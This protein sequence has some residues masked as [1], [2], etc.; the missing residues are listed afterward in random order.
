MK[1]SMNLYKK[2]NEE[3]VSWR[4]AGYN[5]E[6]EEV[7]EILQFQFVDEEHTTLKF[8]R[9]PQFE[10]LETYLYLRC[11]KKTKNIIDLYKEY[12]SDPNDLFTSLGIQ[13][14]QEDLINILSKGGIDNLFE[15]IKKDDD[16]VKKYKLQ[17][18][19][20]TLLL[21][22]PSYIFSLV[23]G[24]GKTILIGCIIFIEFALSLITKQDDFLKNVLVFAPGK[25]I[26]GS[27]REISFID[28]DKILPP[29]FASILKSNVKIVYTQDNQ[30]S[31]PI[32]DGSY[33]NII[34][35]N[36]E[37]IRIRSQKIQ[38]EISNYHKQIKEN[39]KENV[40]NLRLQQLSTLDGLGIFSDEAHNTY[41]QDL[42]KELKKVRQTID[43]LA[44]KT[45]LKIVIN[46]TGTPYYK[47]Q[48]LKDVVFWYGLMEGIQENVLKDIRGNIYS[49]AE[50]RDENFISMVLKNFFEEYKDIAIE[51]GYRSKIAIYFPKIED[52]KKIK[53]FIEKEIL[54]YGLDTNSVFEVNSESSEQ[55]K[56]IFINRI[57][58]KNLPYRIFLLVG[59]G[60]EGWN[61][62]SLFA[63]CLARNLGNSNNFVLQAS[64]RCLR[65]IVGNTKSAR[66]YLSQ[67]NTSIL[68]KQLQETY[69][70]EL[71]GLKNAKNKFIEKKITL[72]KYDDQLPQL[73]VKRKIKRYI[74]KEENIYSIV[75]HTP[76]L[77]KE[78]GK[79]IK[80]DLS[81]IKK[82]MLTEKE[83]IDI[84]QQQKSYLSIYEVAQRLCSVYSLDYFKTFH[85]LQ[86]IFTQGEVSVSEFQAIKEQIESQIDNYRVEEKEVDE[87]LTIIKKDG[88]EEEINDEGV[89]V[90]T[91]TILVDR[92]KLDSL[93]KDSKNYTNLNDLS[94][95][96][97]PYKFDSKLEVKL[98][99]FVLEQIKEKKE[100]IKYFLF[101]G[102]ITDKS[103]T[104]LIFEYRDK[105]GVLR[106]YTPD[107]LIIK[108]NGEIIFLETKGKH[109]A[110]NFKIKEE[111]FKQ[112]LKDNFTYKLLVSE[113]ENITVNDKQFI[114]K[115]LK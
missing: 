105:N 104:D 115:A 39:E 3:V 41:G 56:D 82:G 33:Y 114:Y 58:D 32:I 57:N 110:E 13:L 70:E 92:E 73:K 31:I 35:T 24:A 1:E 112:Y 9:K 65:Q 44:G 25:T 45:D 20:E 15:I 53:P 38:R 84:T 5:T 4:N 98:F 10:A 78:P 12:F 90:Y 18:L 79:L 11:V 107:F 75:I 34:I 48:I 100:N 46:T 74:K 89:K 22:Y 29:R 62:P 81:K 94:F 83:I 67:N 109:L 7:K 66:I 26:L 19:R 77:K 63:C 40:A 54:Q 97:N 99:D 59:M 47:K 30:K 55:D 51:G 68:E 27:L 80:Y 91:T 16:F 17:S 96:Y 103:K 64:T 6:Y 2:I 50:V 14:A 37:K 108:K 43:Y 87:L 71:Q 95:H 113:T 23:M 93:L 86:G 60:K 28:L 21:Q 85:Q 88:F 106:N 49:Y 111:Y 36:V 8:L 101:V 69:G 102:G 76:D 52:V 61:C 42:D 72:I